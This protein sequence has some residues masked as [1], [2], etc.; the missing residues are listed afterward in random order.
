MLKFSIYIVLDSNP[1]AFISPFFF[2]VC[3]KKKIIFEK[4]LICLNK[5]MYSECHKILH[6]RKENAGLKKEF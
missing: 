1:L 3:S 5:T 2:L 4:K 6:N